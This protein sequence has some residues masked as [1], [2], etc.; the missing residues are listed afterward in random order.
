MS[1]LSQFFGSGGLKPTANYGR[2]LPVVAANAGA[3]QQAY[4]VLSGACTANTL[5]TI[6]SVSGKGALAWLGASNVDATSRTL[7]IK[8][9]IDGVV[10]YDATSAAIASNSSVAL[11][12]GAICASVSTGGTPNIVE[13]AP[14]FYNSSLLIEFATSITE[15]DLTRIGYINYLR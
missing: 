1:N 6:L 15:T 13:G 3:V 14:L 12:H 4:S 8:I 2:A 10:V 7:S 11:A 5:K 9:T